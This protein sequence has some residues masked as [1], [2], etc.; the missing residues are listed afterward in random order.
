M[1][2]P[3]PNKSKTMNQLLISNDSDEYDQAQNPKEEHF[4][5]HGR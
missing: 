3:S 5:T 2:Q 1:L 4:E